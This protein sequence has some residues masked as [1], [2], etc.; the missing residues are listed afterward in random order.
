MQHVKLQMRPLMHRADIDATGDG[1]GIA[2]DQQSAS[3]G[4]VGH[5][6][7]HGSAA[8]HGD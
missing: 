2:T 6:C 5:V 1:P 4:I 7:Q 8:W 3:A